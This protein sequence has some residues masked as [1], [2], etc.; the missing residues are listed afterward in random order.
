M[1][2]QLP[3]LA[4]AYFHQ[5]YDLESESADSVIDSFI[6]DEGEESAAELVS[7]IDGLLASDLSE[8]ELHDLW[9]VTWG[10][11]YDPHDGRLDMRAWLTAIRKRASSS[12]A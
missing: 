11:S 8:R 6:R 4:G 5:D 10:A 12:T 1:T 3:H 9:V 7:E 2:Q